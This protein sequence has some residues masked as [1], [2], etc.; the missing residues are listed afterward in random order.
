MIPFGCILRLPRVEEI[1]DMK[2]QLTFLAAGSLLATLA[3]AQPQGR[4][5]IVDLGTLPGGHFSQATGVNNSSLVTGLSS[6]ADG[7]QRGVLWG[8]VL[9]I[10]VGPAGVN[11]GVFGV[12]EKGQLSVQAESQDLDPNNENFCAYG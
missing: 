10:D 8:G 11:S 5:R 3:A 9:R 2:S 1:P 7:T 4:Y 6:I 12:N